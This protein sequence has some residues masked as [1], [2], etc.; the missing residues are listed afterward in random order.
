MSGLEFDKL[1]EQLSAYLDGELSG[2]EKA[3]VKVL[4]KKSE[5]ARRR[6]AELQ[7]VS[8]LI[9][10]LPRHAAPEAI[11]EDLVQAAERSELLGED[12]APPPSSP[13]GWRIGLGFLAIA[14]VLALFV[15]VALQF[16]KSPGDGLSDSQLAFRSEGEERDIGASLQSEPS[17]DSAR[18]MLERDDKFGVAGEGVGA[19]KLKSLL[20]VANVEQKLVAGLETADLRKHPFANETNQLSVTFADAA[21]RSEAID[22]L[23][24]GAISRGSLDLASSARPVAN[25]EFHYRG[26]RGVNFD[27][28]D[29]EQLLVRVRKSQLT[30]ILDELGRSTDSPTDIQLGVGAI[31][32]AG[33]H[34]ARSLLVDVR[35]AGGP[36]PTD[37]QLVEDDR[38]STRDADE[39]PS[40]MPTGEEVFRIIA[41]TLTHPG[42][43]AEQTTVAKEI[44]VEEEEAMKASEELV[45]AEARKDEESAPVENAG[46]ETGD[47]LAKRKSLV[48]RRHDDLIGKKQAESDESSS[49]P[50]STTVPVPRARP[51]PSGAKVQVKDW[52]AEPADDPFVTLIVRLRIRLGPKAEAPE[53]SRTRPS[54]TL[55]DD[56]AKPVSQH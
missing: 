31:V 28:R 52:A 9:G 24:L 16:G 55:G 38:E 21:R 43:P 39:A 50:P 13:T 54:E 56:T 42:E 27:Q 19:D 22:R 47:K 37:V 7:Q 34:Q 48:E 45:A 2:R 4:L 30:Q 20:E 49:A 32:A 25:S 1:S 18:A 17:T 10:S 46:A 11:A 14:A 3:S 26:R 5:S 44:T 6:L 33:W 29:E 23:L 36:T 15:T 8:A 53:S 40:A 12:T 41:K 51:A 35:I